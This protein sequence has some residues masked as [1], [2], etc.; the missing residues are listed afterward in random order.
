MQKKQGSS[1]IKKAFGVAAVIALRQITLLLFAYVASKQSDPR[2]LSDVFS[3]TARLIADFMSGLIL[4]KIPPKEFLRRTKVFLA[5]GGVLALS[6]AELSVGKTVF[7]GEINIPLLILSLIAGIAGA[8]SLP[9][10]GK[11]KHRK[12]GKSK[13]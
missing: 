2:S 3:Y 5:A 8:V 10:R 6:L 7:G 1:I 12:H 9:Q 13:R 4:V 11:R